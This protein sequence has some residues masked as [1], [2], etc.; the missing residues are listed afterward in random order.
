MSYDIYIG[1]A[2]L[3]LF[4]GDVEYPAEIHIRVA[5]T[6]QPGAP[7]F[8]GDE[9]TGDGNSRHPGYSQWHGFCRAAGLE[10]L[11]Y[12][13][14]QGFIREHPGTFALEQRHL[15]VVTKAREEWEKGH[16]DPP[17]FV[18]G[19]D[20]ILARIL[21]L[22]WWMRWALDNCKYPAIHNH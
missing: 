10:D 14:E 11:F 8:E 1:E 6:T 18:E 12:D 19:K 16:F 22:E 15:D 4:E 5:R 3:E 21:W 17:G 20:Y 7:Q 9:M 13:K 2:T